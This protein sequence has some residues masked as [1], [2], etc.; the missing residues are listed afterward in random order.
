[1]LVFALVSVVGIELFALL[2][3]SV[4]YWVYSDASARGIGV[5]LLW[6]IGSAISGILGIYYL[7]IGRHASTRSRYTRRERLAQTT[8]FAESGAF[9]LAFELNGSPDPLTQVVYWIICLIPAFPLLYLLIY[10]QRYKQ[11]TERVM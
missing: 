9:V 10:Q 7:L 4:C 1:M 5:P 6:G 8:F 11:L 2:W 3:V